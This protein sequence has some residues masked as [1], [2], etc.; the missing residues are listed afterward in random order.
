MSKKVDEVLDNVEGVA[1]KKAEETVKGIME[2]NNF[3][4]KEDIA[5]I[6]QVE[7]NNFATK[8]DI[9]V[10][11]QNMEKNSKKVETKKITTFKE[12]FD[13]FEVNNLINDENGKLSF[14]LNATSTYTPSAG[15]NSAP[16]RD[17][18]QTEIE[19][20]P[21]Q[22]SLAKYFMQRTG[23]GGAYRLNTATSTS[24]AG[25]KAKGAAFGRTTKA[26]SD[27]YVPYITVGHVLTTPKEDLNDTTQLDSYF[28]EEMMEEIVDTIN[29]QV[30]TGDGSGGA[31][32]R[33]LTNWS[34]ALD[35]A[36]FETLFGTRADQYGTAANAIDVLV[37]LEQA[38]KNRN[39]DNRSGEFKCFVNPTYMA[40]I[41][42]I[43]TTDGEYVLRTAWM[44][45][46][47][48]MKYFVGN[49][50]IIES[51]AVSDGS[52]HFFH[53]SAVKYVT[54]EGM[55]VE[56]G[57]DTDDWSRNNVSLKA[58]GRYCLVS[59]KPNGIVNGTFA[60]AILALNA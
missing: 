19:Y 52:F 31:N 33:G 10:I 50:E 3:A 39:F 14:E 59:G 47:Q 4:T 38:L 7:T 13:T 24:N 36:G 12:A 40:T 6:P 1:A 22:F 56:V 27:T 20:D 8:E 57:Y 37:N 25:G 29:T 58:Y 60:N 18:R 44:P 11:Q 5:N 32:L 15:S 17:D 51:S 48:E 45:D 2:T 54:R 49:V 41:K 53:T 30:L 35:Q 21:H 26:V 34:S 28:N 55:G 43:K 9:Q 23:S 46:G 16:S 42:G